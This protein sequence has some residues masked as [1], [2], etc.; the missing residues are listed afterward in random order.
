MV[1]HQ[2]VDEKKN[3]CLEYFL[4]ACRR[5]VHLEERSL[6]SLPQNVACHATVEPSVLGVHISHS[7]LVWG[8]LRSTRSQQPHTSC[9]TRICEIDGRVT[10]KILWRLKLIIEDILQ[11]QEFETVDQLPI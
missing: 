5:R 11:M 10:A 2:G 7:V 4:F 1:D 8:T 3:E 6:D 9:N